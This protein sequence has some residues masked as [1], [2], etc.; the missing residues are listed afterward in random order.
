VKLRQAPCAPRK[1]PRQKRSHVTVSAIVEATA[2]ILSRDGY[3]GATT[4]RVAELAGVGVGSL[5]QYFPSRDALLAAVL[6]RHFERLLGATGALF[7]SPEGASPAPMLRK[8]AEIL[9]DAHVH[10]PRL[11]KVLAEHAPRLQ[12]LGLVRALEERMAE[13]IR[14]FWA[15]LG[16]I[17][18]FD[19]ERAIF[20]LNKC[21]AELV[22]ATA[23]EHPEWLADGSLVDDLY[24]LIVGYLGLRE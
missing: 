14:A 21:C 20:V 6:E 7:E 5:Y 4:R 3:D 24:R 9:V 10:E 8:F 13:Q 15:N 19:L 18:P 11:Q 16:M 22:R 23:L 12:H 1:R 17:P 2:R